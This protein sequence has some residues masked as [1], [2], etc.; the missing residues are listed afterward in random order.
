MVV[1]ETKVGQREAIS[2]SSCR[3]ILSELFCAPKAPKFMATLIAC[4]VAGFSRRAFAD[5]GSY[6]RRPAAEETTM[7]RFFGLA[8]SALIVMSLPHN[9]DFGDSSIYAAPR[10]RHPKEIEQLFAAWNSHDPDRVAASFTED[11]VYEDVTAGHIS[12]GRPEVRKWA[13]GGL[14]AFE[15]FEIKIVSS[16]FHNGHGVAEWV[17][18]GNDKEMFKTGKK[19]SVR[20]VR[21]FEVRRAKISR[22]QEFYDSAAIMKQVGVLPPEKE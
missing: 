11:G 8:M 6:L 18:G 13:E 5:Q 20:G 2:K 15:N 7:K 16:F 1:R 17:W 21:V 10:A 12:R 22:Y 19:F 4:E 9:V 3:V 14:A